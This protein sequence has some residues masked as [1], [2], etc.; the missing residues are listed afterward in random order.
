MRQIYSP[1]QIGL[2]K[3]LQHTVILNKCKDVNRDIRQQMKWPIRNFL[4]NNET[5]QNDFVL[6]LSIAFKF[7]PTQMENSI[8]TVLKTLHQ[9]MQNP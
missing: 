8:Y 5:H 1:C 6:K 3:M 4:E 2:S 7:P 9:Q